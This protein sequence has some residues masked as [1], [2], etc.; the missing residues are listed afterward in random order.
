MV[1]P[2][3]QQ[4]DGSL[5]CRRWALENNELSN[6]FWNDQHWLLTNWA[7]LTSGTP[8]RELPGA[9]EKIELQS[10]LPMKETEFQGGILGSPSGLV[11]DAR[12]PNC[13]PKMTRGDKTSPLPESLSLLIG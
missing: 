2:I 11:L 4:S 12:T 5:G 8:L 1:V 6:S 7:D 13:G 10:S 9:P 3:K